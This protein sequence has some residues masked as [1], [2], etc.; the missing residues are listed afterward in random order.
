MTTLEISSAKPQSTHFART[1]MSREKSRRSWREKFRLLSRS[2]NDHAKNIDR[3]LHKA[4]NQFQTKM[5]FAKP[6]KT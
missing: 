2:N 4:F 5:S 1:K 6:P 3:E